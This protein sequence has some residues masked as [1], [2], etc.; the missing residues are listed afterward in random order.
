MQNLSSTNK[1]ELEG[2]VEHK[3]LCHKEERPQGA[4]SLYNLRNRVK[5]K[6][7]TKGK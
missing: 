3:S 5:L 1:R 6:G 4:H 7:T 2:N